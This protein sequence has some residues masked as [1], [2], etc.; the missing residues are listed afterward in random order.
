MHEI[1]AQNRKKEAKHEKPLVL[2]KKPQRKRKDYLIAL[3]LG[4]GLICL[5]VAILPLHVVTLVYGLSGIVLYTVG[6][7]WIMWTVM[8]DY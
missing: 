1:L 7:S 4:N 6:L 2:N 8:S 5:A 3:L